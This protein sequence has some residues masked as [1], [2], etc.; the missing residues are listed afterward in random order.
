M[1]KF[2]K[3]LPSESEEKI[4]AGRSVETLKPRTGSD[5]LI[6]TGYAM[7]VR[8]GNSSWVSRHKGPTVWKE[9]KWNSRE[10]GNPSPYSTLALPRHPPDITFCPNIRIALLGTWDFALTPLLLPGGPCYTVSLSPWPITWKTFLWKI[11]IFKI[12][13]VVRSDLSRFYILSKVYIL[14]L[15]VSLE[16]WRLC[17]SASVFN[18]FDW[19]YE[20]NTLIGNAS[21]LNNVFRLLSF[22]LWY[23]TKTTQVVAS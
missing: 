21:I 3:P 12:K 14:F 15:Y 10:V 1:L 9:R 17:I 20:K 11:T 5:W 13:S 8:T 23:N 2:L 16:D 18:L 22:P 4:S 7:G 6:E 19:V